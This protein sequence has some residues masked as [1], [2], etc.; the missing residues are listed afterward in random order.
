MKTIITILLVVL[1]TTAFSSKYEETMKTNID[2]LYQLHTSAELQ[3]L[4]NRFERIGNAEQDKWL[5]SYYA[6]YCFIRSTFFDEME[7]DAK[8]A[9]LDKAQALV[10]QLIKTNDDES[11]IYALQAL[12]YQIRITDMSKGAQYSMKAADAIKQAE[13]LNPQNPRV[14]YLRGSNTF[15]TPKFFGGGA[16]K[17]KPDLEKAAEMFDSNQQTDP[18]MPTWGSVH[19]EQLLSQCE[20]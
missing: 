11:E 15:H 1:S 14:Y 4:A 16:E 17:A 19:N 3:A 8:H 5:P 13:R 6:A 12:L 2:K 7:N 10:N 9:Q 20:E 18:L